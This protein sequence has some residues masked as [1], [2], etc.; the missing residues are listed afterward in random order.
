[1]HPNF[2]T[3]DVVTMFP[4][5]VWRARLKADAYRSVNRGILRAL[6]ETRE[7]GLDLGPDESWQSDPNLHDLEAFQ[8]LNSSVR[9]AATVVLRFLAVSRESFVITGCWAKLNGKGTEHRAHSHPNNYLSGVYYVQV[10]DGADLINFHD[11]R[12]QTGVIRA[13]VTELTDRNTDQVVLRVNTGDLL[14]F[15]S[16][17]EHSVPSNESDAIRISASFNIMF[18]EFTEG[19]S[20]PLW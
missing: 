6:E 17:L 20:K 1:M 9:T 14:L 7:G 11:P 8:E 15:P 3:S 4:T 5:F 13:P 19:M 10:H 2:E 16:W 18:P 12:P